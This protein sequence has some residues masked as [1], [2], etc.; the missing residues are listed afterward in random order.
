MCRDKPD[1]RK[2]Q[3]QKYLSDEVIFRFDSDEV[4]DW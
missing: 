3:S 1:G 4:Y 2:Q